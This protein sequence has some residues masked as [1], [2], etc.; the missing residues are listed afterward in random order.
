MLTILDALIPLFLDNILSDRHMDMK[1]IRLAT[2]TKYPE[3]WRENLNCK[4]ASLIE[5]LY[6]DVSKKDNRIFLS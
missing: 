5:Y 1:S 4:N 6:K 2:I 3:K